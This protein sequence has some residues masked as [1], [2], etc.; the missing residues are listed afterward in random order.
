M[1]NFDLDINL[2]GIESN[3]QYLNVNG[4]NQTT[5]ETMESKEPT[6]KSKKSELA[7]QIDKYTNLFKGLSGY[8]TPAER[9]ARLEKERSEV[10]KKKTILGINPFV[11]IGISLT[12]VVVGAIV[13]I[14]LK[15]K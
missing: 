8:E 14:K 15:S 3:I 11:A 12:L 9:E 7:T 5:P 2:N 10:G 4:N 6:S 13:I 1:K